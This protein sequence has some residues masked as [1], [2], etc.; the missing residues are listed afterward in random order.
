M[1]R[2]NNEN[3]ARASGMLERSRSQD[4]VARR[5]NVSR[6]PIVRL[7]RRVNVTS[8]EACEKSSRWLW[9]EKLC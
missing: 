6:S 5:F 4:Y 8:A 9:K 2:L 3:R 7:V 1:P